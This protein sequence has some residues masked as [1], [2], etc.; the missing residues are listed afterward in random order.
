M[1]GRLAHRRAA[2]A[3]SPQLPTGLTYGGANIVNRGFAML[4]ERLFMAT[5]DAHLIALDR[6]NGSRCGT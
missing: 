2:L 3:L 6:N 4:G 5:L 1:G